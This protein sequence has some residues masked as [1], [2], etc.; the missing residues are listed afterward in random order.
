[1]VGTYEFTSLFRKGSNR[2]ADNGNVLLMIDNMEIE[3]RVI[4]DISTVVS[5]LLIFNLLQ[6]KQF[7]KG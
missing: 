3:V 7:I 5:M 2:F 6:R 4:S 1:M